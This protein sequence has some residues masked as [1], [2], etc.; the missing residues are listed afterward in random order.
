[1]D[2]RIKNLK[3]T[4]FC[5]TRLTRRRIA[6]IQKTVELFPA[7]SRHELA[8]TLCSHL[9]WFTPKGRDRLGSCLR[10][11]E[12][13]EASGIVSLPAKRPGSR[14][15]TGGRRP[16]HTSRSDPGS[17]IACGLKELMP[18]ELEV[19][20][21]RE[22]VEEW[23]EG[24]DRHHELGYRHPFGCFPRYWL[25]DR[26]GRKLGCLLFE[27][28]TTR[29]PCRD[30]WIG[31]RD[32]DRAKRLKGVVSNSRFL[33]FPWVRVPYLASKA[34]SMAVRRL[35]GDW[36]E[37]HGLEPVLVETFVDPAKYRGTCYRAANWQCIGRTKGRK[38]NA[39]EAGRDAEGRVPV[40]ADARLEAGAADRLPSIIRPP[41]PQVAV[42]GGGLGSGGCFCPA[43]ERH[44]RD[45]RGCRQPARPAL[46][47]AAARAEHAGGRAVRFP[48][49][50]L[51][52][53][54]GIYDHAGRTVG[55]VP[56]DGNRAAAA[57]SGV[58]VLHLQ[59]PGQ[60]GR[61][62]VQDLAPGHPQGGLRRRRPT[63]TPTRTESS[64]RHGSAVA[65][66]SGI[67]GR[68]NLPELA[69]RTGA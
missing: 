12:Q 7:L 49:G 3:S 17:A 48:A 38:A 5:G 61:A 40:S 23:K 35:P 45:V 16:R 1:M 22:D 46:A 25:R 8:A 36:Q 26:R 57:G 65:G 10:M 52:G 63:P 56:D 59:C 33:I 62:A 4:T 21:E 41:F 32:R 69:S 27:A 34:L 43:L 51:E 9:G 37:R 42:S 31:W 64:A 6:D 39:S 67:C 44:R 11:L 29:L 24:M 19:V 58:V 50:V 2:S 30:A 14:T 60:A 55:A 18:L 15:G 13:L 28:G 20:T 54:S 47:A 68:W 53:A 66:T